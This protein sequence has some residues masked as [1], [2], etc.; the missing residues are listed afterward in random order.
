MLKSKL[1]SI[2]EDEGLIKKSASIPFDFLQEAFNKN[3]VDWEKVK[4][5]LGVDVNK[6]N[7]SFGAPVLSKTE[8]GKPWTPTSNDVGSDGMV[9]FPVDI[10][11]TGTAQFFLRYPVDKENLQRTMTEGKTWASMD[12]DAQGI[13]LAEVYKPFYWGNSRLEEVVTSG[14]YWEVTVSWPGLARGDGGWTFL[15]NGAENSKGRVEFGVK[16]G[17]KTRKQTGVE[18][19]IQELSKFKLKVEDLS[20]QLGNQSRA[21]GKDYQK[22]EGFNLIRKIVG[23]LKGFEGGGVFTYKKP[24]VLQVNLTGDLQEDRASFAKALQAGAKGVKV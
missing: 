21:F 7:L 19:A 4:G 1:A 3:P 12:D 13:Y 9:A 11:I 5:K 14:R 23:R 15:A 6:A 18:G 22:L 16:P 2:L 8:W 24:A 20:A 17:V 10:P